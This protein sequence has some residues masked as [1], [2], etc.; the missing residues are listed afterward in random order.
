MLFAQYI[1]GQQSRITVARFAM[2]AGLLLVFGL[3]AASRIFGRRDASAEIEL[4]QLRRAALTDSLTELANRRAFEEQTQLLDVP[5]DVASS[6]YLAFIYVYEFKTVNDT[7][8]HECGDQVLRAIASALK[9]CLPH[10]TEAFRVGGDEFAALMP[11]VD[12]PRA[13]EAMEQLRRQ[14]E[15]D[16]TPAT[17]SIGIATLTGTEIDFVLMRQQADAALYEAKL[18]GRNLNV[19]YHFSPE[20]APV[21]PSSKLQAVRRLLAEGGL[22]A[23]FQ[24]I[25][26]VAPR[27]IV[28]YEALARPDQRYGLSGPQQAFEIA[29]LFGRTADLDRLSRTQT[30]AAAA[31]LPEGALLFVNVSPY[32]LVHHSFSAAAMRAEFCAAG[33]DPERVVLEITERSSVPPEVIGH[34]ALQLKDQGFAIAIDDVGSAGNGIEMLLHVPFD[35]LKVDQAIVTTA[36][37]GGKGRPAMMA[38]LAFA[39][40]SNAVVLAEGV[41]TEAS[42]QLIQ[43]I[44]RGSPHAGDLIQLA[45]G[46]LLGMPVDGFD[47]MNSGGQHAA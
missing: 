29:E 25:W 21:F 5:V 30:L 17:V 14:V 31:E 27:S 7:W 26:H 34:A 9:A 36:M 44:A 32:T 13:V 8:G 41:E 16:I 12:Q 39:R 1:D 6:V 42:L 47:A 23:V 37:K 19:P 4:R 38:I 10:G 3:L 43:D 35:Y 2:A 11:D 15:R 45:Q 22:T 46:F 33:V 20:T 40:E 28:G 18:R 24:P